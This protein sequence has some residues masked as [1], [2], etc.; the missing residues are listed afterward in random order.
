MRDIVTWTPMKNSEREAARK[1]ARWVEIKPGG[2]VYGPQG[3]VLVAPLVDGWPRADL[4]LRW[5]VPTPVK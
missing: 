3:R 1:F 4:D 5:V 2:R